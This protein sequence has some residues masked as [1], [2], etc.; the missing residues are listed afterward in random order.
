M[1][2]RSVD[3]IGSAVNS[4][5]PPGTRDVLPDEMRELRAITDS[6]QATFVTAG[7]G[8]VWT[9]ALE[10]EEVLRAGDAGVAGAGYR[11]FDDQGHVLALRSDMT[12]PIARV[13][14]TRFPD[15]AAPLRLCYLA[16]AY[17]AVG[18]GSGQQ[19]EFLQAGCELIGV[20]GPQGEAE[21]IALMLQALDAAGLA[22]H[23]IGLGDGALYRDLLVSL[24]VPAA[25]RAELLRRLSARDL[26][27]LE[28]RVDQLG[29]PDSAR[30]IL[31]GL[32]E[33]RGGPE[34]LERA[35]AM[36]GTAVDGLAELY[37]ALDERGV[38]DR[39]IVD[40]GLV[41]ELGYYT[42]A[43]YE[44]FDPAV[45]FTLGGG[46]RYDE[47]VGRFGSPRPACGFGLDVQRLHIA[48][49]AEEKLR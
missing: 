36:A 38:A 28:L 29:L 46:G 20:G 30:R 33:L 48:A 1:D 37:A 14:A 49:T 10:Y 7:F 24:E 47:L 31:V 15:V 11:M 25:A 34:I 9:P 35:A 17:R 4:P 26:V 44:V 16:H 27:G 23:R 12:I 39:V 3:G 22:R 40:L 18:R 2:A 8:E 43:V 6:L 45:G 41:R 19:R 13:A 32:P 21:V 5:I 42:G